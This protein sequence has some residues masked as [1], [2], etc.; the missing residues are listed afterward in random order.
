MSLLASSQT[1]TQSGLLYWC[2]ATEGG[3]NFAWQGIAPNQPR[4]SWQVSA[5]YP[6]WVD[7]CHYLGI[8]SSGQPYTLSNGSSYP[9]NSPGSM[10]GLSPGYCQ[11]R[12]RQNL[13]T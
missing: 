6:E 13:V 3:S 9:T 8:Q 12:R 1:T 11:V 2:S 4:T 5:T 7:A 10:Y